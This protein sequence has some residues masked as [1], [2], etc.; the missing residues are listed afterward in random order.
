M[1]LAKTPNNKIK[2]EKRRTPNQFIHPM[3]EG[4]QFSSHRYFWSFTKLRNYFVASVTLTADSCR[5]CGLFYYTHIYVQQYTFFRQHQVTLHFDTVD[6]RCG[7][8]YVSASKD[9]TY[10]NTKNY[11]FFLWRA[12]QQM[13]R[14]HRSF[15]AYCATLWWRWLVFFS[16]FCV[17][18][19]RWNE[20]D[21]GKL[22]YSGKNL[23]QCHFDH[24]KFHM[25]WPGI[26][27]GPPGW[28]AGD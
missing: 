6:T 21:S 5:Q 20:I 14:T 17:V 13:L 24:H 7:T 19:H 26:E 12:P 10:D 27:T 2:T 22:K 18:E 9:I 15:G 25:D 1:P 28:E 8:C 3:T 23:S 16:F 11:D 4:R